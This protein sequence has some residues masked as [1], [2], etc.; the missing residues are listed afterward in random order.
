MIMYFIAGAGVAVIS[1]L[2]GAA[3]STMGKDKD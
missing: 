3:A 1:F 2:V